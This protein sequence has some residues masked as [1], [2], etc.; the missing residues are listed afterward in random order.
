M[1]LTAADVEGGA[2]QV[3]V[4]E[5][6]LNVD[7][8]PQA[9]LDTWRVLINPATGSAQRDAI[10]ASDA[11]GAMRVALYLGKGVSQCA[12]ALNRVAA[13]PTYGAGTD[14][15]VA[16]LLLDARDPQAAHVRHEMFMHRPDFEGCCLGSGT[17]RRLCARYGVQETSILERLARASGFLRIRTPIEDGGSVIAHALAH[18]GFHTVDILF[19]PPF[20]NVI[21]LLD[22]L[23]ENARAGVRSVTVHARG[24]VER[25][26]S[27]RKGTMTSIEADVALA[28]ALTACSKLPGLR[29]LSVTA[30]PPCDLRARS[31]WV[32]ETLT[33]MSALTEL[34]IYGLPNNFH[35]PRLRL[36]GLLAPEARDVDLPE[37]RSLRLDHVPGGCVHNSILPGGAMF[38]Q[39]THLRALSVDIRADRYAPA[40]PASLR[41]APNVLQVGQGRRVRT[42]LRRTVLCAACCQLQDLVN[43]IRFHMV[44]CTSAQTESPLHRFAGTLS[45][46]TPSAP[47]SGSRRSRSHS[48]RATGAPRAR[49][50]AMRQPRCWQRS[51]R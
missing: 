14:D 35:H 32:L 11:L 28:S 42:Q 15:A 13:G 9:A 39:L 23:T 51:G 2:L 38:Q 40:E 24:R 41:F 21:E 10:T 36:L 37:L 49:S 20:N 33:A 5:G 47:C 48:S 50:L 45:T 7:A 19:E 34:C 18:D 44:T 22:A 46:Q 8:L 29:R 6:G 26:R 25:D 4:D 16:R 31:I 27:P 43:S 3:D 30:D 17:M 1:L 12:H